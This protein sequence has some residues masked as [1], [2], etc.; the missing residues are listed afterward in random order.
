M[1]QRRQKLFDNFTKKTV[2][3]ETYKKW[4]PLKET[5]RETRKPRPYIEER[6][7]SSRL[8]RSPLFAMRRLLNDEPP[9]TADPEDTSGAY[10]AP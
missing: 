10:N 8:Y 5:V 4:F 9:V 1:E 6:A 7:N 3:N 2:K